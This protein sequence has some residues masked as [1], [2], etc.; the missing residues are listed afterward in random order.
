MNINYNSKK[1]SPVTRVQLLFNLYC[2]ASY[3]TI[4]STA[5]RFYTKSLIS[6]D[7]SVL[8]MLKILFGLTIL[9][10]LYDQ[11]AEGVNCTETPCVFG[12]ESE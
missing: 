8:M 5:C 6:L 9:L 4:S 11:I 3:F 2:I 1:G 7:L 10:S 12:C